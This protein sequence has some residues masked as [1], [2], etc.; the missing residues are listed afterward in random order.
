MKFSS[1][2]DRT[3]WVVAVLGVALV[4]YLAARL[5]LLLA[6]E[7]TNAS[8]VWPPSGIALAAMLLLGYRVWPGIFLGAFAAN[9]VVF[10]ANKAAG[11]ITIGIVS[12]SIAAGNTLEAL[13]GALLIHRLIGSSSPFAQ[14]QQVFKFGVIALAMCLVGAAAGTASLVLSG[15]APVALQWT[16]GLTWWLGDAAGVLIVTP[17]IISWFKLPPLRWCWRTGLE[18]L[19][20]LGLLIFIGTVVFGGR[21]PPGGGDRLLTYLFIPC[22]A[23]AAFRYGTRG[24]AA[25]SMLVTGMAVWG[26]TH[27]LGPFAKGNLND[28]LIL[29]EVFVALCCVTGLVLAADLKER[30]RLRGAVVGRDIAVTWAA[31]LA[32]LGVT[33]LGW[34]FI[35]SGTEQSARERFDFLADQIKSRITERMQGYEQVLRGGAGLFA[36]SHSVERD[37]WHEYVEQLRI[38]E[39]FPGIQGIG[40]I[41]RVTAAEKDAHIRQ[42]R[43]EGFPDYVIKPEGDREEYYPVVYLEPFDERNRRAFGLDLSSEPVRRAGLISARDTGNTAVTGKITLAQETGKNIQAGFLM[44]VPVYRN[45]A[46]KA[47]QEQRR[48]ALLGFVYSPFRV[49]DLMQGILG[50][51]LP[52]VA[53]EI[54]DGSGTDLNALMYDSEAGRHNGNGLPSVF[55]AQLAVNIENHPWTLRFTALPAFEATVDRQKA[56]TVLIAGIIISL[57]FFIVVRFLAVTRETAL[58]LANDMT[59][60]LR[61]SE[62]KF[63][64]LAESANEAIIITD[65]RGRVVSWNRGAEFIFGYAEP[66]ITGQPMTRVMPDGYGELGVGGLVGRTVELVGLSKDERIFPL[67]LSLSAWEAGG[68]QFYSG[69]IR[70]ISER[71][72]SEEQLSVLN[73]RLVLA[74]KA[75][76]VGIWEWNIATRTTW[77]DDRSYEMYKISPGAQGDKYQMWRD[78]LHP[79]DRQRM[80]AEMHAA[81]A[82]SKV[83][84]TEFRIVWPDGQQRTIKSAAIVSRDAAG[85]PV[86]MLGVDLDITDQKNRELELRESKERLNLAIDGSRLALFEWN[87]TTGDVYLSEEWAEFMGAPAGPTH[88]TFPQLE[89]LVHPDDKANQR[90]AIQDALK[91]HTEFYRAEHRVKTLSSEWKWI[92]SHGKIVERDQAGRATKLIGT[93]ADIDYRKEIE[94]KLELERQLLS[95]VLENIESG[96]VACDASG[97]LTLFNRATENMYNLPPEPLPPERWAEHYD[98]FM[99]DGTPMRTEDLPLYRALMDGDVRDVEMVIVPK[100]G[101]RKR[102]LLASGQAM[103]NSRADKLGAVVAMHDITEIK[104]REQAI[105]AALKE[106]ETLLK[107]VYHRVKNNLQ[108]ITS[109]LNLQQRTLPE[110]QARVALTESANRIRAMA[111][112]HEQLYQSGNLSSIALNNYIRDL[113]QRL[114]AAAGADPRGIVIICDAE[115]IDIGL[116]TAVPFGL[117]LNELV[118]NSLKHGFP[119]GRT[120]EVRVELRRLAQDMGSLSVSDDGVGLPPGMDTL[121][122]PSLGLKLVATLGAQLDG[123]L[124]L[125]STAGTRVVFQFPIRYSAPRKEDKSNVSAFER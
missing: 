56:E 85:Q 2:P 63:R 82:G 42:I 106:K 38:E 84:D 99:A 109:L 116:D 18:I 86:H 13:A 30:Q 50:D 120:G 52:G 40:H 113:C 107:E 28:S 29:L 58:A 8:P 31:L 4:Y 92:Q 51:A 55:T 91:G 69:I 20:F 87:I 26:T 14:P 102:T 68:E 95:A 62:T 45:G 3:Q 101:G 76:R 90:K 89:E 10:A 66:E 47:T 100:H 112:V 77:W 5:G 75:S 7:A 60:A 46:P 72:R 79:D 49:N 22:L 65:A 114:G 39:N 118:S 110:G 6:F 54:F 24:V 94:Q 115:P 43:A 27:G 117:L 83:Y 81:L 125:E 105:T 122:S 1:L 34:H 12:S 19:G 71:K 33:I 25:A 61:E 97:T 88:T 103:Y 35:A 41:R 80:I 23:W 121:T 59:A 37:E 93:N 119:E 124:R 96:I 53:L 123:E 44:Y 15:I 104:Q 17:I 11:G 111:L 70:D 78:R 21:S 57:L 73:S 9:L 16:I 36:A 32:C 74:T 108:V 98:L 67:E 48:A 64:S